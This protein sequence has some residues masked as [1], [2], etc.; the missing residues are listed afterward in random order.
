MSTTDRQ[1]I[2]GHLPEFR[3]V[4]TDLDV[5]TIKLITSD[6]MEFGWAVYE[7]F[8]EWRQ[9]Y[10]REAH[11]EQTERERCRASDMRERG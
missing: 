5:D 4:L 2:L 10:E 11:D 7:R 1:F 9:D 6:R 3:E 8:L